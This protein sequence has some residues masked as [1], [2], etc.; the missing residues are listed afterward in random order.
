MLT[1]DAPHHA[2]GVD[3]MDTQHREFVEIVATLGQAS[4]E[5]Y[6]R[7]FQ[8]LVD[9]TRLHF[10]EE[11]RLMRLCRF[12]AIGEHEAEHH[13][14]LGEL[15]QFNRHIKLGKTALARAYVESAL[16]EWFNL[17]LPTMDAALAR[18][19]RDYR[20]AEADTLSKAEV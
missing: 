14:V 6:P 13:R 8:R 15:L 12:T 17:H 10:I 3:E 5:D 1:W 16:P 18:Q 4:R 19:V 9:H 2:L 11:G 20:A 7:L